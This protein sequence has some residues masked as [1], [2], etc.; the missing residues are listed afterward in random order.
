MCPYFEDGPHWNKCRNT[1]LRER[2]AS[3]NSN[4]QVMHRKVACHLLRARTIK[5]TSNNA[6][7]L[8]NTAFAQKGSPARGQLIEPSGHAPAMHKPKPPIVYNMEFLAGYPSL[9][10]RARPKV[11]KLPCHT[12][13][14]IC[15]RTHIEDGEMH[16]PQFQVQQ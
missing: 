6:V 8:R 4:P 12:W 10:S 3:H 15:A 13:C 11:R 2:H 5:L 14:A 16:G 9:M 7:L 1:R